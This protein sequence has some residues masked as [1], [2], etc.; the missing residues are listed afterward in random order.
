MSNV[1][2]EDAWGRPR[3]SEP[4]EDDENPGPMSIRQRIRLMGKAALATKAKVVAEGPKQRKIKGLKRHIHFEHYDKIRNINRQ[5]CFN[6]MLSLVLAIISNEM[7]WTVT[8]TIEPSSS[9]QGE[10]AEP[11]FFNT[12]TEVL[13]IVVTAN[14]GLIVF[15]IFRYYTALLDLEKLRG[16]MLPQDT[17]YSAGYL[18]QW[19]VETTICIIHPLPFVYFIWV[20]QERQGIITHYGSDDIFTVLMLPRI[21]LL[22]RVFRDSW[23]MNNERNRYVGA[24]CRVDVDSPFITF[25]ALMQEKPITMVPMLYLLVMTILSYAI[26]VFERPLDTQF[27]DIRN[28][29]WVIFVT[30]TTVGYGDL[31]PSTDL[32]RTVAVMA[33]SAALLILM[34]LI[35]GMSA[36]MAPDAKEYKVFHILKYKRWKSQMQTQAA[37]VIQSFWRCARMIDRPDQPL[38]WQTSYVADTKLC[39]DVRAFRK[40]RA[41]EP[42]EQRDVGTLLWETYKAV[43]NISDKVDDLKVSME[44]QPGQEKTARV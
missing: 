21:Y 44:N 7:H 19:L 23:G 37:V 5:T 15:G 32:G 27:Q 10:I 38:V 12:F 4:T 41:E 8:K 14:V 17:F 30:M 35:I 13:K 26:C 39:F 42:M 18:T 40:L 6:A 29:I 22:F 25:K 9:S 33:C 2:E 43:G 36:A 31:F 20:K 11:A 3:E 24:L 28:G 1:T 16:S 34:L